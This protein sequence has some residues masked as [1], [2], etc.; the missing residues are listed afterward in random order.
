MAELEFNVKANFD[1]IAKARQELERFRNE[2]SKVTKSTDPVVVQDLTDKYNEQS[3]KVKELTS[4]MSRYATVTSDDFSKKMQS[5]TREVY[6]FELQADASKRK[7]EKLSTEIGKMQ[8]KLRQGNLDSGSA[9][10]LTRD[11]GES[12]TV[13]ADEQKR[14][15]NLTGLGKQAK[16]ELQNMQAEYAKYSGSSNAASDSVRMM[17]DALANMVSEM[18]QVP[19]VGEGA[20]SLLSRLRGD[21]LGLATSLVG[22]L[23]F[24]QLAQHI[25]NVRSE[26]QQLEIS[27][28]TMLGSEQKSGALMSQL[29]ST[30]AKTPFDMSSITN[31][32]K[33]LLAY[34]TAAN[35]VN[36]ILVHLGD[37]SAGLNVPLG[38]LVYLYGTTMAQGRMYTMD[39]RQFMGR[40]IP[41]AEELG[42][43]MGKTTQE[44]QEAVSK[45]QVGADLVKK[46]IEVMTAEGGKFG[47]LMEKQSATLQGKWSNI[48]DSVDQMFNELGKK[49][50]GIFGTGLDLISS[51]VDNWETV[52]KVIGTAAVA[53][54]TYK[55]GLMAAASIQKVQNQSTL[56]SISSNLDE[57]IQSYRE[58]AELYHSYNGRDTS[59]YKASRM[60][61]LTTTVSNT[62]MIGNEKAEQL[63]SLKIKEA[64]TDGIITEQMA[65]QL[66]LK[67]DMLVAQQQSAAKE[68]M[69]AD[70]LTKGLDAK[71]SQYKEM[72]NDY[73]HLNG[74]DTKDY[75][76]SRYNELGDVLSDTE[77]I[78]DEETEQRVSKQIELAKSEGL[79]SEEMAKQLQL[80]RDLLV[81]QTK[82]AEKEQLQYENTI[83]AKQAAEEELRIKQQQEEE[84]ALAKAKAEKNEKISKANDTTLGKAILNTNS[85]E[86]KKKQAEANVEA[87]KEEAQAQREIT[88]E[89][90][91]QIKQQE[92]LVAAKQQQIK[93]SYTDVTDYGGYDDGFGDDLQLRDQLVN[94]YAA[95]QE[96]LNELRQK[97]KEAAEQAYLADCKVQGEQEQL[98]KATEELNQAIEEENRIYAETGAD[99]EEINDL[100]TEGIEAKK[101]EA[102]ATNAETTSKQANTTSE[103]ANSTAKQANTAATG[104]NTTANAAN[105]TSEAANTGATNTN[106]TSENINTGAKE[107]NSLVTSILSVGTKGL[108]LAQNVL[109]YATNAVTTSLKGMWAAMLANPLT[110]VITLVTTAI[111]V[112]SMFGSEEEDAS[113][114][115]QDMGNKAAEASNKVRSLFA[116]LSSGK[117]EDHKDT[118]NELKSAYEEYGVKLDETKMKSQDMGEQLDELKTHENELIGLIEKR[119][120]EMERANQLQEAYNG[121]NT[122]NDTTFGTF[123]DN[124]GDDLSDVE[125]GTIRSLVSQDDID[126]LAQ[127]KQQ[128]SECGDEL[129]VYNALEAQYK[130]AQTEINAKLVTYLTNMGHS[131]S[132]ITN[133]MGDLN[134]LTNGLAENKAE[135]DNGIDAVNNSADAAEN[136]RNSVKGLSNAEEVQALKNQFAKKTFKELN[137]DIQETIKLCSKKIGLDI[138]VNY[139]DSQLPAWI[140]KMSQSQLKASMAVRKSW[141]DTHKK[142]D[143]LQ[144]GG[145]Y[146]TYEQV[147][148]EL[149]MMQARGTNVENTPKKSQKELDKEK[150]AKEKA[151]K[152]AE[153]ARNQQETQAGN[154]KKAEEDY[155]NA[156]SSYSEKAEETISNNRI[157][158]MQEGYEKELEQIKAN[159]EKQKKAIEDGIDKLV[160]AR[161]KRDQTV[162]VNSGKN[163]KANM[164]KQSK[165]DD[166]YRKEVMGEQMKDDKGKAIKDENGNTM[167]IADSYKKQMD[168]VDEKTKKSTEEVTKKAKES[169]QGSIWSYLK[170]YGDSKE[171]RTALQEE[172][173]DKKKKLDENK[174]ITDTDREYQKKSIDAGLKKSL[175][176]L[177]IQDLKKSINWDFVF[178]DL[179]NVSKETLGA[180]KEQLQAFVDSAKD[181]K[182]DEIKTLVDAM[183]QIQE[184]MDLTTPIK[185]IKSAR[186]EYSSLKKTYAA[187]KKEYD[188]ATASGDTAKQKDAA[189]KMIKTEQ[190]M[191][192]AR[193]KEKASYQNVIS[194]AQNYVKALEEVGDAIGGTTGECIKLAASGI[195]AGLGMA[196]GVKAFQTASSNLERSVAILA[197]IEAALQAVQAIT[198]LFGSKEDTTL[199]DYVDTLDTYINLLDDSISELNEDMSDTQ[200]TM[201]DTIAYYEQLVSLEKDSATAIKSQ[202]QTWLN[203][204]ASSGSHSEGIKIR[205][206]IKNDLKSSNAEVRKFY[207]EGYNSLNEYYKKVNGT[208]ANSVNDFGRMD[209]IWKLSDDDLKKL[210][211]DT[212]ALSLLGDTLSSAVTNYVSKLKQIDDDEDSLAES[213]L[214]VS[215]DDFYDDF[216]SLIKDMDNTSAD[217]ANNFAEYMRNALVKN[218]VASEYKDKLEKLYKKAAEYSKDGT[219][220]AHINE[221]RE[222]YKQ[223]ANSAKAEV[224]TI[225]DITGYDSSYSQ[226]ASSGT[227]ET[228]SQDTGEE[229]N[230]R[231]TAVQIATEGTRIAVESINA[232]L[233]Q[234]IGLDNT[235][236]DSF[237]TAN[238]S[239]LTANVGN[240]WVAMDEGRTILAQSLMCLQ[241]IDERQDGWNK[242]I[243]QLC[244][245]VSRMREKVD[246]L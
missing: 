190:K 231:F 185:S 66:Q 225:D 127:L 222:E 210:A 83:N 121:Y 179:E 10:I 158:A 135:L 112:F 148:N 198:Q 229:L 41:M 19:T 221:L 108:S 47:G 125:K 147:A 227:F 34:G 205:N 71:M 182:P 154:R 21:A 134:D 163:R 165:S 65:E 89:L 172:A 99:A 168:A 218:L 245:D 74:K 15:E 132:E 244:T 69:E 161:K 36:D 76:A 146:K 97:G 197:I 94:E 72:E 61:E 139:D 226:S 73:R 90:S 115:T 212:K 201:K 213:L 129:G 193:S 216:T 113:A 18:K 141:L 239:S 78:G 16:L 60:A 117:A 177:D 232:K 22:G 95:E 64:Q 58:Q 25:F 40:G 52:V 142:G 28:T 20:S 81:E 174:S 208:Y 44:V 114:K 199:T 68:Q 123:K 100:V 157:A 211:E 4:A 173:D 209:F 118:I 42:K 246:R 136:A 38:D 33:Q 37:I 43:L 80:K 149:A 111:S 202:S 17:T 54:G 88:Y 204:G 3:R 39:L 23:G 220:E 237:L 150:K 233:D 138:K 159:D 57:K 104:T 175:E 103:T 183:S 62:D 140:K 131:R 162:W 194:T 187:Y 26:F 67:R 189:E 31:G 106:T 133:M 153:K 169:E 128:M 242:P 240:M 236:S 1:E 96:K 126:K 110:S 30:A 102:E 5:L 63:V 188:D 206:Q 6:S 122:A 120:I 59:D 45:G 85:Y 9:S 155:T 77:N 207:Q 223:Y 215:F 48:G 87:A 51:L 98:K 219:L 170:E 27:F 176:D 13:L 105:T 238:I 29:I 200:N 152:A 86:E 53:V 101:A 144:I 130:Q 178:G 7:I 49:S 234:V 164:W 217:F 137:S 12:S 186:T 46:A 50:E 195:S 160:E 11:I 55:A 75:K 180:V 181:L 35:E 24:E 228:M 92:E 171:K 109:T 203:S 119:S 91:A 32:A 156:V 93:D 235:E 56:D 143:V 145:Q 241:S 224:E 167:T 184:K 214:N 196:Q 243:L 84:M 151:A 2:L 82:L 124:V 230:G 70:A 191:V 166:E 8:A 79:I 14:Y 116:I 192:K 107:R